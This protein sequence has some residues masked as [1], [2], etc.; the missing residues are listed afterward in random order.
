MS[1]KKSLYFLLISLLLSPFPIVTI[2]QTGTFSPYSRYGIGDLQSSG[3]VQNMAMGKIAYGLRSPAHINFSNPASY[4]SFS[5]QSFVFETGV[6]SNTVK[7]IT[8]DTT[9]TANHTLLAYLSFGFPVTKWWGSSFGLRPYSNVGYKVSDR[10]DIPEIGPVTY[11]YEGS[12]GLNQFYIGNAFKLKSFSFGFNASY[13]FGPIENIRTVEFDSTNIFDLFVRE[14][15]NIGGLHI[16]FGLQHSFTIDTL[17]KKGL[18]DKIT[19]TTGVVFSPSINLDAR[20]SFMALTLSEGIVK[21]LV[22]SSVVEGAV[23]LPPSIG[24]G[25]A[26]KKGEKWLVGF[27]YFQQNWSDFDFFGV[28]DSL[29]NSMRVSFG[30]QYIPNPAAVNNFLKIAQYRFGFHYDKTYLQLKGIQ[31]QEYGIS[32]G[33]GLPLKR[34]KSTINIT[35]EFGQRGTTDM[36]LIKEQ[37]GKLSIGFALNDRW[38]M[39]RKFD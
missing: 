39:K 17:F 33:V 29:S 2:A 25:I 3:F 7:L 8:D 14:S 6:L 21:D 12:G 23:T 18:K 35:F 15:T 38:F 20:K 19:I 10:D 5:P 22:D 36:K 32:F 34:S 37:F 27:D 9:Q 30:A 4:T 13:L 11:E 1:N 24:I 26:L 31:L 16:N 28:S